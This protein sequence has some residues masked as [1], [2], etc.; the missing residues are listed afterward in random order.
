MK[1]GLRILLLFG[2]FAVLIFIFFVKFNMTGLVSYTPIENI[3]TTHTYVEITTNFSNVSS[4]E[5]F[6]FNWDGTNYTFYNNFLVLMMNFDNRSALGENDAHVFDASINQNNGTVYGANFNSSGKYNG[7]F[8]FDGVDDYIN[9]GN[10][11]SL[12]ITENI[13]ISVWINSDSPTTSL[14]NVSGYVKINTTTLGN[15]IVSG[16]LLGKAVCSIGDLDADGIVDVVAG[17]QKDADGGPDVGTAFIMFMYA[18]GSVKSYTKINDTSLGGGLDDYGWFGAS[19]TGLGDLNNDGINDIAV[20]AS[21]DSDGASYA[22]AIWILFMYANG[23]V[24]SYTKINSTS[25]GGILEKDDYFAIDLENIGDLDGDGI[26]DLAVGALNDDD[27]KTDAGAVYIL[28]MYANASVKSYVKINDTS[29]DDGL[30]EGDNFGSSVTDVGDLDG[31]GIIDLAVGAQ[32]ADDGGDGKGAVWILF[33][34]ANGSVKSYTKI[35]DTSLGGGLDEGD[36]F[37]A[38]V[39]SLGDLDSDGVPELAIGANKDDD[40]AS[41][42]GAV[43]VAFMHSN[44]SVKSYTKI[45]QTNMGGALNGI[46]FGTAV[47]NIGDLNGDGVTDLLIGSKSSD[48]GPKTGAVWVV[49]LEDGYS[50]II[51]KQDSYEIRTNHTHAKA[52]VNGSSLISSINSGWNYITLTS[53]TTHKSLYINGVLSLTTS[54]GTLAPNIYPVYIGKYFNGTIDEPR[55][56]NKSLSA[57][58]I[59]QLYKSNLYKINDTAWSFYSNQKG[60]RDGTYNYSFF[61]KDSFGV[62]QS[63]LGQVIIDYLMNDVFMTAVTANSIL[64]STIFK[65]NVDT[66]IEYGTSSGNYIYN[67]TIYTDQTANES[68]EITLNNLNQS[69]RYYFR[70]RVRENATGGDY[71]AFDEHNFITQRRKGESF[72]FAHITDTHLGKDLLPFFYNSYYV[73]IINNITNLIAGS[74]ADFVI[75]TG[76]TGQTHVASYS[77]TYNAQNQSDA[78]AR[79]SLVR[80]YYEN[81]SL[82]IYLSLGNHDAENG[83]GVYGTNGHSEE[84]YNWSLNARLKYW[85]APTNQ[86]YNYGGGPYENYYAFDWGDATFIILDSYRYNTIAP[87]TGDDWVLGQEQMNWLETTLSNSDKKWKFIFTHHILGGYDPDTG[88]GY[89]Y[90]DGGGNYSWKGDQA[91][92]NHLMEQYNAQIF[93]YG[94]VHRFVHDWANWSDFGRENYVNY[95]T[96][97]GGSWKGDFECGSGKREEIYQAGDCN[98]GYTKVDVTPYNTTFSFIN[99]SNNAVLYSYTINN[100]APYV[101]LVSPAN[102]ATTSSKNLVFRYTDAEYDNGK[103]CNLY[104]DG[105]QKVSQHGTTSGV[106]TTFT[107]SDLSEGTHNWYVNCSDGALSGVSGIQTFTYSIDR[108]S[109]STYSPSSSQLKE[110]YSKL[111]RKNQKVQMSI[112]EQTST[113]VIKSVDSDNKKVEVEIEEI[114]ERFE[115]SENEIQK[116]DLDDDGYY[117]LQISVKGFGAEGYVEL[118]FKEIHEE[119]PASEQEGQEPPSKT[120]FK[121]KNW[122]WVVGSGIVLGLILIYWKRKII[123]KFFKN[124]ISHLKPFHNKF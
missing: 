27:G 62:I 33:M 61:L 59:S 17:V 84:L 117:D 97:G 44:G 31:D 25:L 120:E 26:I 12:N 28:F 94:H 89:N 81:I 35:N 11:S 122:M 105:V 19:C 115:L 93:F 70:V 39:T 51:N 66:Y 76:D 55:I 36:Y 69:T 118:E 72:T 42:L 20:G 46:D 34:Y 3:S 10:D 50:S 71:I 54:S 30:T 124:K 85:P 98:R 75:D 7:A 100:T 116:I 112:N 91:N 87:V 32:R 60:L 82:P 9:A 37:G 56:W 5:E 14:G 48:G 119:V 65:T 90:G 110:G 86:T 79:Y 103:N 123:K 121:I 107:I 64:I 16:Q 63:S 92:I 22:G 67:S 106:D 73:G 83:W 21:R 96:S 24:K 95:V 18:N 1:R 2:I 111:L 49:F 58:E 43:W 38:G 45:N 47:S 57:S 99:W 77:P 8:D 78:D 102:K 6:I 113:A 53:N 13:T 108:G 68:I 40:G 101:S 80:N 74:G 15:E 109:S 52:V 114:N 41:D 88:H 104:V 29:L 23:S 4:M